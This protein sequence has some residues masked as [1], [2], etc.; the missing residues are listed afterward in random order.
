MICYRSVAA[1]IVTMTA[2]I[3]F[4]PIAADAA[5]FVPK[6]DAQ[7]LES[8]LPNADP[9]VRQMHDIA[10]QL[11]A[12]PDD[13]AVAM[14]LSARQLAM[15]VDESDPRFV[16][17]AQ[18]TLAKWWTDPG[19][20]PPLRVL[21]A[22]IMQAQHQF[23]PAADE[24][25]RALA[26]EP[27][28]P[29]A[30]LLLASIDEV[31]GDFAEANSACA[32]FTQV[33]PGLSAIACTASVRAVTGAAKMSYDTLSDAVAH[34]TT[35][36]RSQL[37]W[38]LTILGETAIQL[39]DPAADER[40]KEALALDNRNV[41]AAAAYADFLLSHGRD[42]EVLR[43]LRGFDRIDTLYLRFALAAQALGDP[44]FPR[45]RD[46]LAARF[47]AARQQG[48]L[49]HLRDAARFALDIEHDGPR[50]LK[51]ALLNWQSNHKTPADLR[52]LLAAAVASHDADAVKP[53]I[54]WVAATHLEDKAIEALKQQ[55]AAPGSIGK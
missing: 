54:E 30:L 46:D 15:G 27:N 33:H 34:I 10:A 20:K 21:R 49:V 18:G 8:G 13:L 2:A 3:C 17:Y 39:D 5:P 48:D 23:A 31:T 28:M 52:V 14:H 6:D 4:G 51:L 12:A 24:L 7:V 43:R 41:Y 40:F 42:D 32:K 1:A 19:A 35:L 9:R 53:A 55:L 36:D 11:A 37:L 45:Y 26:E 44:E 50:A 16:G 29:D 47:A 25:H 22:R 38:S